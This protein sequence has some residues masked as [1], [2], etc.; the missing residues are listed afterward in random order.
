MQA[1]ADDDVVNDMILSQYRPI[2]KWGAY[3]IQR[4]ILGFIF[5]QLGNRIWEYGEGSRKRDPAL[6]Q[7]KTRN[8]GGPQ[9]SHYSQMVQPFPKVR[10]NS[11]A[12]QAISEEV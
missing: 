9:Q 3:T 1:S 2:G 6:Y 4:R 8:W 10:R 7:G 12:D 5:D 11:G